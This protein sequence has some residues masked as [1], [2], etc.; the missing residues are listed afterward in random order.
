MTQPQIENHSNG[1]ATF[2][3]FMDRKRG[4]PGSEVL[5]AT[6]KHNLRVAAAVSASGRSQVAAATAMETKETG[7]RT[8]LK[9]GYYGS[10][11]INRHVR[12]RNLKDHREE[13]RIDIPLGMS[14]VRQGD[15][16][17]IACIPWTGSA[18]FWEL[19]PNGMP[20]GSA[21][22][23]LTTH[24]TTGA[25]ATKYER[26]ILNTGAF[27]KQIASQ[28]TNNYTEVDIPSGVIRVTENRVRICLDAGTSEKAVCMRLLVIQLPDCMT[29]NSDTGAPEFA[30]QGSWRVDD[31]F[32]YDMDAAASFEQVNITSFMRKTLVQEQPRLQGFKVLC[33]KT[34][35]SS[36]LSGHTDDRHFDF[37]YPH[38]DIMEDELVYGGATGHLDVS[39]LAT[40]QTFLGNGRII[41]GIF[42]EFPSVTAINDPSGTMALSQV[43]IQQWPH[44][45]GDYKFK[46]TAAG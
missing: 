39:S 3:K 19:F 9:A 45:F 44:F 5:R 41:W 46:F 21:N 24:T 14:N 27:R 42:Y 6:K 17:P 22:S 18:P 31:F 35:T 16:L 36:E 38:G 1:M 33:D 29:R 40:T 34:F 15:E 8:A 30:A 7:K 12:K 32:G 13:F 25:V 28:G 11:Q 43:N 2:K 37:N 20:D 26:N 10:R 4:P 23:T